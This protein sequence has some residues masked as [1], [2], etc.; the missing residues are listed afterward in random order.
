MRPHPETRELMVVSLHEGVSEKDVV[1]ATG[2]P[3]G[4]ADVVEQ[5]LPPTDIELEVLRDLQLR[6]SRAHGIAGEPEP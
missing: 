2:W 1:E 5:T 4:F 6:T 3:I